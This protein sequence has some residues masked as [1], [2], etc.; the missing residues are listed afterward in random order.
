LKVQRDGTEEAVPQRNAEIIPLDDYLQ[1]A[2]LPF[3][4]SPE[5]M[6]E[7]AFW[8]THEGSFKSAE[9]ML[10]KC[11]PTQITDT[12]IRE[13]T[14]YVGRK[15]FEEDDRRARPIEKNMDQIPDKAEEKGILYIMVD[16][17]AINTR[18][19]DENGSSWRENKLGLVFSSADLRT[20]KDEVTH[21]IQR[22]GN[23]QISPY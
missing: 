20:R 13:V 19:Q 12:L 16:G 6:A 17:A 15:V 1:I 8:G 22:K 5:M 2:G 3:K 23:C 4:M 14:E 11:V 21:D 18:K 10:R 7:T 9:Q